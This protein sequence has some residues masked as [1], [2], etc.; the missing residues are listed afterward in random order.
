[1]NVDSSLELVIVPKKMKYLL[2]RREKKAT[3]S[4]EDKDF[5]RKELK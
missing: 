5:S 1:V 4:L 3:Q 2:L